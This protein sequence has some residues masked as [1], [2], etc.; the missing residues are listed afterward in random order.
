MPTLLVNDIH[1]YYEVHGE[2]E[3]LLL[4]GGL[5][6]DVTDYARILPLLARGS[7]V[8]AFD[9]RGAGR[10]DKPDTPYTV[11]AMAEDTAGLLRALNLTCVDVLGV[12]MGGRI[13]AALTL[14]HPE[15]TRRLILVSTIMR[16]RPHT[17]WT[18]RLLLFLVERVPKMRGSR[19]YPQPRYAFRHQREASQSYDCSQRLGE[20][21][22]PT[23]I[24]HGR[25]D[26]LAPSELVEE[27][28][29]GIKGSRKITFAGGHIF[30]FLRPGEFVN[31][32]ERFLS[33]ENQVSRGS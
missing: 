13:A 6:N 14:A 29:A 30:P 8:V 15:V 4:I 5:S 1:L 20:I 33:D 12:S 17:A 21:R 24:L 32:V 28:H 27:M 19:E 2:G 10:S 9:N 25:K 11:E 18:A 31:A 16:P 26:K 23:L 22:V 7:K 3:P